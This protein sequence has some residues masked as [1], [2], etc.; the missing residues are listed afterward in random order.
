VPK[1]A[2]SRCSSGGG[3]RAPVDARGG[4]G[5]CPSEHPADAAAAAAGVQWAAEELRR[6]G[7]G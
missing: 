1:W 7:K 6:R 5:E 2:P 3:E 4:G